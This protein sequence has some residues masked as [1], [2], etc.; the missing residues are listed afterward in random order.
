MVP[1][2]LWIIPVFA[3]YVRNTQMP[4]DFV[5]V[6]GVTLS[7]AQVEAAVVAL[8]KVEPHYPNLSRVKRVHGSTV[9]IVL[10]GRIQ[11]IYTQNEYNRR[12]GITGPVTIV[13]V[14]G[15]GNTYDSEEQMQRQW[16]LLSE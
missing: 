11:E 13:E 5:T 10:R 7:R 4:K 9:G 3:E 1:N 16:D 2:V 6:D 8:N 15:S 12:A 14:S